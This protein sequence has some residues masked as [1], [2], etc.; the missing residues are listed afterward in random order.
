MGTAIGVLTDNLALWL[1]LGIVIGMTMG[2]FL[3]N[4]KK[5]KDS[6][7]DADTGASSVTDPGFGSELAAD[8][9]PGSNQDPTSDQS[10]DRPE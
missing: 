1:P 3:G 8:S 10:V 7:P 2:L 4:G 5:D 6:N 9:D